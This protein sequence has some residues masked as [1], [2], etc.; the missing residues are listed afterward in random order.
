LHRDDGGG[1]P[2]CCALTQPAIE[3]LGLENHRARRLSGDDLADLRRDLHT[4]GW[5]LALEARAGAAVV[6]VLGPGRAAI[7]PRVPEAIRLEVGVGLRARDF[8]VTARDG[9]RAPVERFAA[10]R[11]SAV[12]SLR[13]Q[14]ATSEPLDLLVVGDGGD[15]PIWLE[16]Y[17]HLLSGWWRSVERYRRA[18][19]PPAVVVVCADR[20]RA[21]ALVG[22]ADG[23]LCAT[24]AE[25]GVAPAAWERAGRAGIHFVAE[26]DL[27]RGLLHA[28]RVPLLPPSLR[29]Q[30]GSEP[31][32]VSFAQL[33]PEAGPEAAKPP[34]R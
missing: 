12:V 10:V 31:L 2:L 11:P 28:W 16:A 21:L 20:A 22:A 29:D 14:A 1:I 32:G 25:I 5:L 15:S 34:W 26:Q 17:D 3:V 19:G 6:E 18:G 30:T 23:L 24:V 33:P 9:S 13:T 7:V 27:H 8:L 4:V